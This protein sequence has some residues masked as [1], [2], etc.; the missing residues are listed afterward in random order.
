MAPSLRRALRGASAASE[1]RIYGTRPR[2]GNSPGDVVRR[3]SRFSPERRPA[4]VRLIVAYDG[5]DFSGFAAQPGQPGVRTVGGV[6]TGRDRQGARHEVQLSCAGRT[7]AGVHAWGQVVGFASEPGDVPFDP[8]RLQSAVSSMLGP[9]VVVR[10]ADLV[11][12]SFDTRHSAQ[13]RQYRY[14][15][16]NRP[17]PDPFRDRSPGGFP[18]RSISAALRLAADPFVGSHDFTSF[19]RK[20]PPGSSTVRNVIHSRWIDEGDGVLRYEIHANAFCWQMV[21][22]IVGTLVEVGSG[23]RKPGDMMAILRAGDRD[24]AGQLAPPT[25][26]CACGRSA[27]DGQAG[28]R[29][30]SRC[31]GRHAEVEEAVGLVAEGEPGARAAGRPSRPCTR[32]SFS[33]MPWSATSTNAVSSNTPRRSTAASISPRRA[34]VSRIDAAA[35]SE[36]GPPSCIAES[37]SVKLHH[38]NRGTG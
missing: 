8:R 30:G 26:D 18:S 20:G 17:V 22:S 19:C 34:S 9:E 37:V 3:D 36:C 35:I 1:D 16:L 28:P 14:T 38:M 31:S 29:H 27:I 13:W 33:S 7:D 24:T 6:L 21:R 32:G 4:Q 23:K 15:I 10:A 12:P 5:T 25:A 2:R 11:A